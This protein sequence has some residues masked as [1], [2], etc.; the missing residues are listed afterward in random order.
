MRHFLSVRFRII[1]L[2]PPMT[3]AYEEF[4]F[5]K[6]VCSPYVARVTDGFKCEKSYL[7]TYPDCPRNAG[8]L[9]CGL[10]NELMGDWSLEPS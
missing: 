1:G 4:F 8:S 2:Q 5:I 10:P 7:H 9:V 6:T 3:Q